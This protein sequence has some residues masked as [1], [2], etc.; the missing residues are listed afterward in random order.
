VIT[1]SEDGRT[2]YCPEEQMSN[3]LSFEYDQVYRETSN[4]AQIFER[5]CATPPR[6][7]WNSVYIFSISSLAIV[8][9]LKCS[10]L[11]VIA[12]SLSS[13]RWTAGSTPW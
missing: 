4:T 9:T 2:V 12:S 1:V 11:F 10:P 13:L 3:I 8:L 6:L 5:R 7:F